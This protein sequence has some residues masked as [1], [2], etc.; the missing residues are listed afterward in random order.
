MPGFFAAERIPV[1]DFVSLN[2]HLT[3][4]VNNDS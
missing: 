2:A 1:Q 4:M 3:T